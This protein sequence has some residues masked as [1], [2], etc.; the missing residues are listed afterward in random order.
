M[1]T[2]LTQFKI[3]SNEIKIPLNKSGTPPDEASLTIQHKY[4]VVIY[5]LARNTKT[6]YN[7]KQLCNYLTVSK[8]MKKT[9]NGM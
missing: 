4:E 9:G 6:L 7:I 5:I 8:Y 3:S 2:M 1:H